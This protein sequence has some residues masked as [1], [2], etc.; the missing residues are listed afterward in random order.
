[1]SINTFCYFESYSLNHPEKNASLY[2]KHYA[3]HFKIY[4]CRKQG[5]IQF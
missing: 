3:E 1:M 2:Q 4:S 5:D